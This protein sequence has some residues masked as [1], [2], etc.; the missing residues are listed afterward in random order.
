MI[1]QLYNAPKVLLVASALATGKQRRQYYIWF[2][3]TYVRFCSSDFVWLCDILF[4]LEQ[5]KIPKKKLYYYG[6]WLCCVIRC[7]LSIILNSWKCTVGHTIRNFCVFAFHIFGKN[8]LENFR[9]KCNEKMLRKVVVKNF[10]FS[11]WSGGGESIIL[12]KLE[13]NT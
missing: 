7:I 8:A 2:W 13:N 1:L 11:S 10:T 4:F 12:L 6:W 9:Q 5:G 3:Y